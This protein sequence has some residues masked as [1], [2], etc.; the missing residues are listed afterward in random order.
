MLDKGIF[1][2]DKVGAQARY[3]CALPLS[4]LLSAPPPCA[5]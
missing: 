3:P 1:Q 4:W 2:F 5:G